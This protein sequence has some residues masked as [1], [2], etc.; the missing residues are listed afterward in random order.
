MRNLETWLLCH[1][2]GY[3]RA[4][5]CSHIEM[6]EYIFE[7]TVFVGFSFRKFEA[8]IFHVNFWDDFVCKLFFSSLKVFTDHLHFGIIKIKSMLDSVPIAGIL[9]TIFKSILGVYNLVC[10][11]LFLISYI[12]FISAWRHVGIV[13]FQNSK[14]GVWISKASFTAQYPGQIAFLNTV[15][16]TNLG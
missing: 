7:L 2:P 1:F 13:N 14:L 12:I 6:C 11:G 8:H 15:L 4:L 5:F 9:K 10:P 3:S 16:S